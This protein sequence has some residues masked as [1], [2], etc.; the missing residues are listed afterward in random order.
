TALENQLDSIQ[1]Y[2]RR[3]KVLGYHKDN[4]LAILRFM[5]RLLALNPLD[6][7][8]VLALQAAIHAEA[9]LTERDWLLKQLSLLRST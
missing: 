4:Y 8:E 9:V 7:Q 6:T 1:I 2:L 3:K 5:R